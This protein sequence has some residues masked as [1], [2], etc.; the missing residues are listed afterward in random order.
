LGFTAQNDPSFEFASLPRRENGIMMTQF[1]SGSPFCLPFFSR[2]GRW[3]EAI[4][5]T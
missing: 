1:I 3:P 2:D 5:R 4:T